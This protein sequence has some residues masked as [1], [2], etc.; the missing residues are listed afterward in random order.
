MRGQKQYALKHLRSAYTL[1]SEILRAEA[2]LIVNVA[3]GSGTRSYLFF[4]SEGV[5]GTEKFVTHRYSLKPCPCPPSAGIFKIAA[6]YMRFGVL[7]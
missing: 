6:F 5:S 4:Q 1:T 2:G 7:H 3:G